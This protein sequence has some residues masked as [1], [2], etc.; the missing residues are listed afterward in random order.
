MLDGDVERRRDGEVLI[1]GLDA[2]SPRVA[3]RVEVRA[4]A[5]EE[6]LALVGLQRPRERFDQCGLAGAVVAD[7]REDLSRVQLEIGSIQRDDVSVALDDSARFKDRPRCA[8]A[9]LR[10]A[11]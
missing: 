7:N 3:W 4:L 2:G 9:A 6:D 8:H 11:S 5:V 1:D 10:W